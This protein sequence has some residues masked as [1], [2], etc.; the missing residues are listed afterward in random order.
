MSFFKLLEYMSLCAGVGLVSLAGEQAHQ[1]SSTSLLSPGDNLF[2]SQQLRQGQQIN[3]QDEKYSTTNIK[4]THFVL[5]R[6][7]TAAGTN[8]FLNLL[9]LH[10]WH[11]T[12]A[13]DIAVLT[14]YGSKLSTK[15]SGNTN[16]C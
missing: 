15:H 1:G 5:L 14:I 6:K 11:N 2:H 9:V 10:F 13:A 7:P 12:S 4:K 8:D 3:R 16:R